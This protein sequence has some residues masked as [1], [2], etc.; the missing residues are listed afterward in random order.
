[1]STLVNNIIG[2]KEAKRQSLARILVVDTD[3]AFRESLAQRLAENGYEVLIAETGQRAFIFLR[4]RFSPIEWLFSRAD[5]DSLIDGWILADEY[6]ATHPTRPVFIAT[7][8]VRFPTSADI[9]LKNPTPSMVASLIRRTIKAAQPWS[10]LS[11]HE[12][13]RA[14]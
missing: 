3:R 2:T 12:R 8:D 14:A 9:V 6:H 11:P 5:L 13:E 10:F 4:D 1:M 7:D